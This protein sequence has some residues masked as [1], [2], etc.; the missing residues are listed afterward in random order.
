MLTFFLDSRQHCLAVHAALSCVRGCSAD[1]ENLSAV[2]HA[3][4]RFSRSRS[5]ARR[6]AS[7]AGTARRAD[8]QSCASLPVHI[9]LRN[10]PTAKAAAVRLAVQMVAKASSPAIVR[11]PSALLHITHHPALAVCVRSRA[12]VSSQVDAL[13]ARAARQS[14][15]R[16]RVDVC[17]AA[18]QCTSCGAA[19][20]AEP[21]RSLWCS[22]G[23]CDAWIGSWPSWSSPSMPNTQ[24]I[25]TA[26]LPRLGPT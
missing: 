25:R 19:R 18:G 1:L 7:R 8:A 3:A 10:R 15:P 23:R 13:S 16:T 2:S 20:R 24:S 21:R 11:L 12:T 9:K 17:S 22:R 5:K 6:S 4:L 14:C 26:P